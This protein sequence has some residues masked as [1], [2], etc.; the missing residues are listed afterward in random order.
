MTTLE[1]FA[2]IHSGN[3]REHAAPAVTPELW[4]ALIPAA[5]RGS[6][7]GF[8]QPK[9]LYPVC[10]KPILAWLLD[11]LLPHCQSVTLV[12]SPQG[13]PEVEPVLECLA[14]G[15]FRIAVQPEPLGMGDAADIGAADV[16]TP[17]TAIVWGDQVALRPESVEAVLRLHQGPLAPHVTCPTVQRPQPY[18]HFPRDGQGRINGLLQAR[19]GDTLPAEGESDTGFFCFRTATLRSLLASL[20]RMPDRGGRT[21]ELNLLPVIPMAAQSTGGVL[22]PQIMA[23]EETVG[24]NS[25]TDALAVET[26]LRRYSS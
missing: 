4:T 21:G 3:W 10:G 13:K 24:I 25:P 8:D 16:A 17:H 14:P 26:F 9:I 20:R 2:A 18:I 19:E 5:G 12:L 1:G 6:R 7:L 11:L 15:R 23:I 22:T